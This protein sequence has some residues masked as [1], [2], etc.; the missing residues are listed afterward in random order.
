[1]DI[2]KIENQIANYVITYKE[3]IY[4]L[5]FSYVK[6]KEDA[7][8]I[9][10]E[11][12]CKALAARDSL[13][14]PNYIKTWFYRI[15]VNTSL[16]FLHKQK[17]VILVEDEVLYSFD[18]GIYDDYPDFD[19]EKAMD[20]LPTNYKTIVVLRFFEDCKI[21]EIAEILDIN[22]NTV[23]TQLYRALD[24]LRVQLKG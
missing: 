21:D 3:K 20:N 16:D 5:A 12:I 9:V 7:L 14:N 13:K 19:L 18:N 24:K 1:M 15:I 4:R 2:N 8:D 22:V 10:Q 6:N 11:S 23:K 17:R